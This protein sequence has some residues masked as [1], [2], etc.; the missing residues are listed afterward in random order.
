MVL[1]PCPNHHRRLKLL[2]GSCEFNIYTC[3]C[4]P[5]TAGIPGARDT[6]HAPYARGNDAKGTPT[7]L[8]PALPYLLNAPG[9]TYSNEPCLPCSKIK[10][11]CLTWAFLLA[12]DGR[13]G[14]AHAQRHVHRAL[15][16]APALQRQECTYSMSPSTTPP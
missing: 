9:T 11:G 14:R 7:S 8:T 1:V 4:L 2:P 16:P 3:A 12:G 13:C 6:Y 15:H 10:D 5:C